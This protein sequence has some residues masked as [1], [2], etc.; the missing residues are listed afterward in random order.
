M[1]VNQTNITLVFDTFI[2]SSVSILLNGNQVSFD[3]SFEKNQY[4]HVCIDITCKLADDNVISIVAKDKNPNINL[5]EIIANDIKFGLVT[6]L[7]TTINGQ[8]HT[9]LTSPGNIDIKMSTPIWKFWCEK[10]NGF[11]YKDYPLGSIN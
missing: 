3:Q 5:I 1:L 10:M 8:Q 7:C 4:G 6:F 11:N 9:Q 2:S